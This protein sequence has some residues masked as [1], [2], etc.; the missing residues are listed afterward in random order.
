MGCGASTATQVAPISALPVQPP[1]TTAATASDRSIVLYQGGE[2]TVQYI[3][4]KGLLDLKNAAG[5]VLYGVPREEATFIFDAEAAV[6][7][8]A[9]CGYVECSAQPTGGAP[10]PPAAVADDSPALVLTSEALAKPGGSGASVYRCTL[11]GHPGEYAVKC[12]PSSA[13]ADKLEVLVAEMELC[14][15]L[16]APSLVRF[17]ELSAARPIGGVPHC[18]LVMELLPVSLE[19][20]IVARASAGPRP[21]GLGMLRAVASQLAEALCYMHSLR[22]AL[23]HRDINPRNVFL[24]AGAAAV[25]M[26]PTAA[27]ADGGGSGGDG[28]EEKEAAL[29]RLRLGDFDVAVRA[30]EPLVDF[31]GTPPQ[32]EPADAR[33]HSSSPQGARHCHC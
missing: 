28:G 4:S 23:L 2:W 1:V 22:P 14:K 27:G 13:R 17:V 10:E 26:A 8:A 16:H 3:T 21:F 19:Q 7:A 30:S 11:E 12:M 24:E 15:A 32:L 33:C 25:A 9:T 31:V 5:D 20:V 6:A 18:A 29:G